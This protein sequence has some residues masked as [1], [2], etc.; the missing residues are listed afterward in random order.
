MCLNIEYIVAKDGNFDGVPSA[1]IRALQDYIKIMNNE[2]S[3]KSKYP[4]R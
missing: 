4:V 1:G 3:G 2:N